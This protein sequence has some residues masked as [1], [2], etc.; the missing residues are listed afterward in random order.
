MVTVKK[1]HNRS[2]AS[3]ASDRV[4]YW[5]SGVSLSLLLVILLY[6]ILYVLSASFSSAG[7]VSAGQVVLWPV[8][9]GTHGY[10]AVFSHKLVLR[11]FGN[12]LLYTVAFT[13]VSVMMTTFA[14]YPLSRRDY[15][16]RR[17]L[18]G[19][20][21]FTMFFS[22]GMIPNYILMVQLGIINTPWSI[23]LP[24]CVT[25]YNMIVLRSGIVSS[26]PHELL[27]ASQIDG[28]DDIAYFFRILLPLL[29]PTLAVV[30]LFYAVAQWNAYFNAM[31]YLSDQR[32][33][34]LQLI[35][36]DILVAN[37]LELT[38]IT[39]PDLISAHQGMADLLKY[40]LIVVSSVPI[41]CVYP[42]VQRYFIK[43]VMIGSVKG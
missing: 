40:A 37:S 27:E 25:A 43:G 17:P 14:A 7:A 1:P 32:L 3:T 36:R 41:I 11:G 38:D 21:V 16:L 9:P 24:G 4:F 2:I 5:V 8:S 23:I 30:T 42:F 18:T 34:P 22:G 35:L 19:L 26:I 39:D 15:P 29:K 12:S 13:G 20:F 33:Y 28:C 10:R 31:M 6:P